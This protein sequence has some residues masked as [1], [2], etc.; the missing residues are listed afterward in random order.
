MN[1]KI[2]FKNVCICIIAI[3]WTSNLLYAQQKPQTFIYGSKPEAQNISGERL[4]YI[5]RLLQAYV[6]QGII[7]HALTF[8]ARNGVVV[9]NKAFGWSDIESRKELKKDD[10]F[11]N[12]SQTKAITTVALMT[13]FEQG[14]FQIDDPVSKYIPECTDQV[15]TGWNADG[16]YNTRKVATP[17]TIRNI[18]S[19]TS[20]I[21]GNRDIQE[22]R[23]KAMDK[24][25]GKPYETLKEEVLDLIQLPLAFDPGTQ[26][27][28]HPASDVW[29]YLVEYFS[30][31]PLR[32]YV[33]EAILVPLGMKE[34]DWYY[35]ESYR[36]RMVTAYND[37][38]GKLIPQTN[39]WSGR[40]PFSEDVRYCQSGT[41]LNGTIEDYARFCQ[42]ILNGGTF[43]GKRILGRRTIEMMGIDQLP[44][45]N[46]GGAGFHFGIGFQ[47]YPAQDTDR[48]S[49]SNFTPMVSPGSLSWGGMYNTDYLIDSKEGLI[50]LLYTN[51]IPDTKIWE[52]F[53]NTVYQAL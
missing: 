35:P 52:K 26:W 37:Q 48:R 36:T 43:N 21:S 18:L 24:R 32:D 44:H 42:M 4:Q 15:F 30:G 14:K 7:P 53:L 16:S 8:V 20:G 23:R 38:N 51:R 49:I 25:G 40:N 41:G 2:Y 46:N 17:L 12:Y 33:K 10:I 11:R 5:D 13:L 19:H 34:S 50:I 22:I 45:P 47:I 31:K 28:Y 29:G 3:L 9:H 27:N 39:V 6:D 1:T